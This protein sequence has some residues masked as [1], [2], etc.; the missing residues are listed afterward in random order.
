MLNSF[1]KLT[2]DFK[3]WT[4]DRIH[5]LGL[6]KFTTSASWIWYLN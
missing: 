1:K 6:L 5:V 3:T 4:P 2:L